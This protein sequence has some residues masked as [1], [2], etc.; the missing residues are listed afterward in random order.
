MCVSYYFFSLLHNTHKELFNNKNVLYAHLTQPQYTVYRV[1][2]ARLIN[3]NPCIYL[4]NDVILSFTPNTFI[5]FN[6]LQTKKLEESFIK[7]VFVNTSIFYFDEEKNNEHKDIVWDVTNINDKNLA[8]KITMVYYYALIVDST[9]PLNDRVEYITQLF[10]EYS[11]IDLKDYMYYMSGL[12][13]T[14]YKEKTFGL[15]FIDIFKKRLIQHTQKNED[16]IKYEKK[17]KQEEDFKTQNERKSTMAH[18]NTLLKE[19]N[20]N[21]PQ[22][23][24]NKSLSELNEMI[25]KLELEKLI[26]MSKISNK[27]I[28]KIHEDIEKGNVTYENVFKSLKIKIQEYEIMVLRL[29]ELFRLLNFKDNVIIKIKK[30]I[31]TR[32]ELK[33]NIKKLENLLNSN[34]IAACAAGT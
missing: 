31:N 18:L 15:N 9:M 2:C 11:T 30:S 25:K 1:Y 13:K 14:R 12:L 20:T 7:S 8:K 19:T 23:L 24:R 29:N 33:Q 6:S 22:H 5:N 21:K 34:C 17:K 28:E 16:K 26:K 10:I 32:T 4:L 3:V 27:N